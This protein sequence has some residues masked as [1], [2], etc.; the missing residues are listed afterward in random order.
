MVDFIKRKE[1]QQII[2]WIRKANR[3]FINNRL[4]GCSSKRWWILGIS[5][6]LQMLKAVLEELK[7]FEVTIKW[8]HREQC[9]RI[10]DIAWI[11]KA[12]WHCREEHFLNSLKIRDY[13][14]KLISLGKNL[15]E[16]RKKTATTLNQIYQT[17][18]TLNHH[19]SVVMKENS[20]L[21]NL[22]INML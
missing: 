15:K 13:Q 9:L 17:S 11:H 3:N 8:S 4:K 18:F 22:M 5:K 10:L 1:F 21:V 16:N 6:V 7:I 12:L 14:L 2:L 20:R 19:N